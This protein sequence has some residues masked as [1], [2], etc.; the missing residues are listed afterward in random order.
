MTVHETLHPLRNQPSLFSSREIPSTAFCNQRGTVSTSK[1]MSYHNIP[2]AS[3]AEL[4]HHCSHSL[5][6]INL[7][8]DSYQIYQ[9]AQGITQAREHSEQRPTIEPL[10]WLPD[11]KQMQ[12][13]KGECTKRSQ[14]HVHHAACPNSGW[15]RNRDPII[16]Q[17][18]VASHS[19]A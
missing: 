9:Q 8:E 6:L 5:R 12:Q 13:A 15:P 7:F 3:S 4:A 11:C 16:Y 10:P 17:S 14:L 1:S 18:A 19:Q 2:Q